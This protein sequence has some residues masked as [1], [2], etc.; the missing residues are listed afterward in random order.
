[1]TFHIDFHVHSCLSPCGGL[2]MSPAAIAERAVSVGLDAVCLADH[3][4]AGNA[5]AFDAVCRDIP[6][7]PLFGVEVNTREEVHVLC[8]YDRLEGALRLG[9]A[10]YP[11][12]PPTG[13]RPSVFGDQALVNEHDEVLSLV[14]RYLNNAVDLG[15]DDLAEFAGPD[16]LIIPSHVD[17]EIFGLIG[18]LGFVPPLPFA[19]LEI[20]RGRQPRINL[21]GIDYPLV[22]NSDAHCLEQIGRVYNRIDATSCA[23]PALREA[24]HYRRTRIITAKQSPIQ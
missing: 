7:T 22:S 20:Y 3:N 10:L 6:L 12:L 15:I 8:I 1:M 4:A 16:A 2:E 14:D 13:N 11:R 24:L 18:Q 19:A 21:G 23:V 5:P 9:E 17:R